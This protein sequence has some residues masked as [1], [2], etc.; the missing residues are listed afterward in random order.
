[1]S[2]H[3][4]ADITPETSSAYL[5]AVR[6]AAVPARYRLL[7]EHLASLDADVRA[8]ERARLAGWRPRLVGSPYAGSAANLAAY[9]AFREHDIRELQDELAILGL[10]SLG[11][12]EANVRAG[13]AAVRATLDAI[14]GDASSP[15]RIARLSRLRDRQSRILVERTDALLGPEPPDRRCRVMVTMPSEAATDA[16]LVTGLVERGM[17]I[18]RINGAHDDPQ[19]WREMAGRVRD[20]EH[21]TGRPCRILLDLPGPKLRIAPLPSGPG[22]MRLKAPKD[23]KGPSIL[24]LDGSGAPGTTGSGGQAVP[25]VAVDP[26]WLG[27]LRVGVAVTCVDARGRRRTLQVVERTSPQ[28]VSVSTQKGIALAQGVVLRHSG[29]SKATASTTIGPFEPAPGTIVIQVGD[30]VRFAAEQPAARP[31]RHGGDADTPTITCAQAGMIETLQVG[32]R[33]LID[34]GHVVTEVEAVDAGGVTLRVKATRRPRERLKADQGLNFPDSPIRLRGLSPDDLVALDVAVDVADLVG[35]SFAQDAAD[36]D[37]LIDE[38]DARG[39]DQLGV[40]AKIETKRGVEHLPDIIVAAAAR[41]P[42]GVMIARGDLAVEIGYERL[43]EMQEQLLWL[44]EAAHVPAIWAT[45]VLESLVKT[46]IPTRAELTD[47]AMAQRA[48]CVMLNKGPRILEGVETLVDVI[49]RME[50]HQSKKTPRLRA[51]ESW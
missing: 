50:S 12:V 41:R 11:R 48:E 27:R 40:V 19:A 49:G 9:L 25:R 6:S 39:A 44:C 22:S 20:A 1:M 46:G 18:A 43:A 32:H 23:G 10:S 29:S 5:A 21:A 7:Q 31:E 2:S 42:L 36:L 26:R 17:D 15:T 45:Q 30:V 51:L 16:H 35:L 14:L 38:L 3:L 37:H 24:T 33:V 4:E 28:A 34:D 8:S 13:I 47:A